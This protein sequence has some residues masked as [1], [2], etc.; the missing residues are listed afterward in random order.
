MADRRKLQGEI[1]RCLKKVNE[2]V[3]TF[4][5]IWQKL[6]NAANSNQKEKYEAD[7]KKEIK[8][9]QR[10]R[11]QIKTWAA[12]NEIK[13]KRVLLENR[14]RIEIQMERFKVVERETKT[15]AYSK[16]GLGAATKMDPKEKE[17]EELT[18]WIS[19]CIENLNIQIDQ[20][21]SEVEGIMGRKRKLDRDKQDRLDELKMWL[22]KHRHHTNKLEAI[23]RML[24]N[25]A[26]EMTQIKR[27]QEDVEYYVYSN[28]EPDFE[29]NE[30]V[31]D[32]L[33]LDDLG[34]SIGNA[35]LAASP[36]EGDEC[37]NSMSG[38][39]TSN[40]SS[41]P[42]PSPSLANHSKVCCLVQDS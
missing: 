34:T 42:S 40:N 33:D 26:V 37:Q 3:E 27:I 41:S 9:L 8:K 24:D 4:E 39:P 38:T 31:Y 28:Q 18:T 5:D 35:I 21:E 10:L 15:K 32:D 13:D 22:E 23:M 16:E 1:E 20:F 7:L 19:R 25:E 11:D 17:K 6:H 2:G 14:K 29:E 36:S 12:S 30:Y